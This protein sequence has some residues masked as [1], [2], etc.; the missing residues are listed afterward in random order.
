MNE[1][2]VHFPP[3]LMGRGTREAGEGPPRDAAECWRPADGHC[4]PVTSPFDLARPKAGFGHF[5]RK[6]GQKGGDT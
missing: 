4:G 2:Q 1:P 5:P 3:H 6:R